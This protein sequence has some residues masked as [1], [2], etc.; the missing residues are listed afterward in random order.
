[1][2]NK[3]FFILVFFILI[4]FL[5]S[6]SDN[7]P[8]FLEFS[9][10]FSNYKEKLNI[11]NG[12]FN[13]DFNLKDEFKY[14]DI[15][16]NSVLNNDSY[17]INFNNVIDY[18]NLLFFTNNSQCIKTIDLIKSNL[19]IS[20][21]Y[22][23]ND[24]LFKIHESSQYLPKSFKFY[25]YKFLN[26]FN[27]SE[28]LYKFNFYKSSTD[29]YLVQ[30]NFN[31][32]KLN[33]YNGLLIEFSNP[34]DNNI[35][36]HLNLKVSSNKYSKII[37]DLPPQHSNNNV[38]FTFNDKFLKSTSDIFLETLYLHSS[39]IELISNPIK[40]IYLIKNNSLL[41]MNDGN[42]SK[43]IF[44]PPYD[45]RNIHNVNIH[46]NNNN[47]C[48]KDFKSFIKTNINRSSSNFIFNS[49][50]NSILFNNLIIDSNFLKSSLFNF[51]LFINPKF[52]YYIFVIDKY[53]KTYDL[54]L[55]SSNKYIYGIKSNNLYSVTL[56]NNY[57]NF[58]IIGD[59]SSINSVNFYLCTDS[60]ICKSSSVSEDKLFFFNIDKNSESFIKLLKLLPVLYGYVDEDV[61]SFFAKDFFIDP[62]TYSGTFFF[63]NTLF[64][65]YSKYENIISN[66]SIFELIN[67][68]YKVFYVKYN[69]DVFF[70]ILLFLLVIRINLF[71]TII[72]LILS[73]FFIYFNQSVFLYFNII[74]TFNYL[75]YKIYFYKIFSIKDYYYYFTYILFLFTLIFS[76]FEVNFLTDFFSNL[77]IYSL[78]F[79]FLLPFIRIFRN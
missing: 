1:M 28:S 74:Y 45:F 5:K 49:S 13:I 17:V 78:I 30:S 64:N 71:F 4:I 12:E 75:F 54:H 55:N 29:K 52:K 50:D 3:L 40:S 70:I 21:T 6:T 59:T 79:I 35:I 19:A 46:L 56:N 37:E 8:H 10:K 38:I 34:I 20:T 32:I 76:I 57:E 51:D 61:H 48:F 60:S 22:S 62:E 18:K 14:S 31:N 72:L 63:D 9:N 33:D 68:K 67:V 16:F 15:Y 7:H 69:F 24:N 73:P 77:L 25:Y 36:G 43:I 53:N 11:F 2:K 42:L 66:F 39:A 47:N 58:S 27:I 65:K 41:F 26:F 44:I 23:A